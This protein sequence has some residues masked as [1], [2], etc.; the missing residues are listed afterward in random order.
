M[1]NLQT[2]NFRRNVNAIIGAN[3]DRIWPH[4]LS[5]KGINKP[6]FNIST[7]NVVG[8]TLAAANA[9]LAAVNLGSSST[10]DTTQVATS[11]SP[12]A[13]TMVAVTSTVNV[14]YG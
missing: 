5:T 11:Q 3:P 1:A 14:K 4:V 6:V 2:L 7:P 12:V 9:A 13:T 8:M 10:G